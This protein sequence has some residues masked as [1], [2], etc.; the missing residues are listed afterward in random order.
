MFIRQLQTRKSNRKTYLYFQWQLIKSP[1]LFGVKPFWQQGVPRRRAW[2]SYKFKLQ[3]SA[4]Y[5]ILWILLGQ[6]CDPNC[7][8]ANKID[9]QFLS[10]KCYWITSICLS[11]FALV[12]G[13]TFAWTP[14]KSSYFDFPYL[15]SNVQMNMFARD[16]YARC[17]V[18]L[19][20]LFANK[21]IVAELMYERC[22]KQ[23]WRSWMCT[24]SIIRWFFHSQFHAV[25]M[26]KS[27][28]SHVIISCFYFYLCLCVPF[29]ELLLLFVIYTLNRGFMIYE[30]IFHTLHQA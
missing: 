24:E 23:K 25:A 8:L 10:R 6:S 26:I 27:E 20:N 12:F 1:I 19:H 21:L 15:A 9:G 29:P 3:R 22:E 17:S 30:M 13:S 4:D 14:P 28:I 5:Q 16:I 18:M 11:N 2:R 7:R